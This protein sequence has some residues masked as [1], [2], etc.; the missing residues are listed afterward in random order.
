MGRPDRAAVALFPCFT[1]G[2]A[3]GSLCFEGGA[4]PGSLSPTRFVGRLAP[5]PR[6][7]PCAPG[8]ARR[9]LGRLGG[10]GPGR[11]PVA[12]EPAGDAA[13][14]PGEVCAPAAVATGLLPLCVRTEQGS[15][16]AL[17]ARACTAQR[18]FLLS[19]SRALVLRR[20]VRTSREDVNAQPEPAAVLGGCPWL[21]AVGAG[22]ASRAPRS[23][24]ASSCSQR[25]EPGGALSPQVPGRRSR[26]SPKPAPLPLGDWAL[27]AAVLPPDSFTFSSLFFFFLFG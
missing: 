5:A 6:V 27:L 23:F 9:P 19:V 14:L 10:S 4:V 12:G 16:W 7:P 3:W 18:P 2:D 22:D 13:A 21:T 1:S 11:A 24:L 20:C 25:R 15:R 8:R 26:W 17:V